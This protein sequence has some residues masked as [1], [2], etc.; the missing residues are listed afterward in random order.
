MFRSFDVT[1]ISKNIDV[2]EYNIIYENTVSA[3]DEFNI[4]A[5]SDVEL[6]G[7]YFCNY[8]LQVMI[9]KIVRGVSL[10]KYV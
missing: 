10:K 5:C 6:H 7:C 2:Y 3:K 8:E 1:K 9:S 4:V